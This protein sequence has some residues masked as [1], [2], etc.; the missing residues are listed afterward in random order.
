MF[1][2]QFKPQ[3]MK[4]VL[5]EELMNSVLGN[6]YDILTTGDEKVPASKDNY[7]S[8]MTPGMPYREEDLDFLTEGMVGTLTRAAEL[9]DQIIKERK[10][11]V[12]VAETTTAEGDTGDETID[13]TNSDLLFDISPEELMAQDLIRKFQKAEELARLADFIPDTSGISGDVTMNVWNT[14]NT[15]SQAFEHVLL[16]SQVADN[17]LS[18]ETIAKIEK[19]RGLLTVKKITKNII[20]DEEEEKIVDSPLKQLYFEKMAIYNEAALEYNQ[21][22]IDALSAKNSAAVHYWSINAK[23]LYNNVKAA[24]MDWVNNGYKEEFE[25]ISAYLEQV[26]ERSMAMLKQKYKEDLEKSLLTNASSGA[27]FYH[28]ALLP[29]NFAKGDSGWTKMSFNSSHFESD[30]QFTSKKG[31][32]SVGFMGFGGSASHSDTSNETKIDISKFSLEFKIAQVAI[33]RPW[34]NVNF[35]VSKYWR[36]DKEN[37]EFKNQ[38]VSD[39]E[40]PPNGMLPAYSTTAIFIKDLTLRMSTLDYDSTFK[41]KITKGRAGFS[42]GSFSLGGAYNSTNRDSHTTVDTEFQEIK[43]DGMQ[44][45]GF[46]CHTLPKSPD[47]NPSIEKWI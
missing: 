10:E 23:I 34:F 43:V 7:L 41:E 46:K 35:L 20:T 18:E 24:H 36:F 16:F 6:L 27:S 31:A 21:R 26:Q 22:R 38:M 28:T 13:E 9:R 15:L 17:E 1:V 32:G 39:G 11:K 40:T 5:P 4:K 12:S 2:I 33:S 45:I 30:N 42:L 25:Q 44:L 29:G 3:F 19:L 14:E 47:P 8:W 37:P